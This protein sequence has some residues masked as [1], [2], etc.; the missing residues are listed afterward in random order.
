MQHASADQRI[1]FIVEGVSIE[2]NNVRKTISLT[3]A[4]SK[5]TAQERLR[6]AGLTIYGT[7]EQ[8]TITNVRVGTYA[9]RTGLEA[10]YK[11]TGVLQPTPGRLSAH[12]VYIPALALAGLVWWLQKRRNRVSELRSSAI[13]E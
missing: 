8:I 13:R 2:G 6:N 1:A 12:W 4:D 11:I 9:K 10:G 3:L 7:G 5:Q